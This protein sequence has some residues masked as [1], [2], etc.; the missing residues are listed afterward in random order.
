MTQPHRSK[1][2]QRTNNPPTLGVLSPLG[3]GVDPRT[4]V[5]VGPDGIAIVKGEGTATL[6]KLSE[7]SEVAVA[8]GQAS[9]RDER[10][11]LV[12]VARD[13]V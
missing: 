3:I 10:A 1:Y 6:L 5:C 8:R 13:D 11:V 12:A 7:V 2:D 9:E 4:A